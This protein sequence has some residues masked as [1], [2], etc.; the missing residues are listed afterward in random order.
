[1]PYSR[2]IQMVDYSKDPRE[3][4]FLALCED[5]SIWFYYPDRSRNRWAILSEMDGK[6]Y[7]S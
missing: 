1:M 7:I 4:T 2:V 5:G 3:R 6:R